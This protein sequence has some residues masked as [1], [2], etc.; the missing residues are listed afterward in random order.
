MVENGENMELVRIVGREVR[1]YLDTNFLS[2]Y[3]LYLKIFEDGKPFT[4]QIVDDLLNYANEKYGLNFD[5]FDTPKAIYVV[6]ERVV[7]VFEEKISG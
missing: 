3:E 2:R 4:A 1:F 7:M 5:E 6:A